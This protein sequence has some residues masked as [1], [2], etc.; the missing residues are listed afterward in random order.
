MLRSR[1][2]TILSRVIVGEVASASASRRR[3][4]KKW[5]TSRRP[6]IVANSAGGGPIFASIAGS[7]P[8][9]ALYV[10]QSCSSS[11]P[12]GESRGSAGRG[13]PDG[14]NPGTLDTSRPRSALVPRQSRATNMSSVWSG[15]LRVSVAHRLTLAVSSR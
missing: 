12:S 13:W 1:E 14:Y 4:L 5:I 11:P 2:C 10:S 6:N 3:S 8:M 15:L 7:P 9:H